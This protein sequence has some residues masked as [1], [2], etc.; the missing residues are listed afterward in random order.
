MYIKYVD[1]ILG[2]DS[3][4]NT[5]K[6]FDLLYDTVTSSDAGDGINGTTYD[7]ALKPFLKSPEQ[8]GRIAAINGGVGRWWSALVTGWQE[9]GYKLYLRKDSAE[10]LQEIAGNSI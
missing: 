4:L 3:I 7:Q 5:L 1:S 9:K 10:D 8:G 6:P 2:P